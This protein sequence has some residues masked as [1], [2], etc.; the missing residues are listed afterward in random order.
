MTPRHITELFS[1]LLNIKPKDKILDPCCGTG[2][3]LITCMN[4]MIEQIS[5]EDNYEKKISNIKQ[6]NIHGIESDK[7]MFAICTT[8]MILRGDGKSNIKFK[9]FFDIEVEDLRKENYT[10]GVMNPPYSLGGSESELNFIKRLLDS[11]ADGARCAVIVQ[12]STMT[13]K[14]G[15]DK[16]LKTEIYNN[17]TLE[18]VISLREDTFNKNVGVVPCIVIFTAHEPHPEDK[19][20][21]FINFKDDGLE[22]TRNGGLIETERS[23]ERKKHL[24]GCWLYNN[25]AE[26]KFMVETKVKPDDEWLHSFYYFNDEIPTEKELEKVM[27]DYLTF[28]FDS[29]THGRGYL[30]ED[31]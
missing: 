26:S 12:Q 22:Y 10:V 30:F 25:P 13:G 2:S 11:L 6:N 1:D 24:L 28:E 15:D 16:K 31:D 29:I 20:C 27:A 9:D 19:M 21:K 4:R 8:N 17:H 14:N 3:F 23:K 18:G 7:N 5:T